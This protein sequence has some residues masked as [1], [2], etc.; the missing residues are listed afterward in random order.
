ME[1]HDRRHEDPTLAGNG[2][3]I[4][5]SSSGSGIPSPLFGR[6]DETGIGP[7]TPEPS[8]RPVSPNPS[9]GLGMYSG[10]AS[11]APARIIGDSTATP[12]FGPRYRVEGKLGEGGMGAVYKAYD[13]ELDRMV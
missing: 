11:P 8:S 6:G 2:A 5:D 9:P 1:R 13:L 4:K 7:V 12:D 3:A 10:A